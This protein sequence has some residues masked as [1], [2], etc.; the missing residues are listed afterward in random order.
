MHK[1]MTRGFTLIELLIVVVLL[2][3]IA[4]VSLPSFSAYDQQKI[5]VAATEAANILRLAISEARRTQG[6][7][8]VDGQS[9]PGHLQLY[10]SNAL[11]EQ[12]PAAGTSAVMDP[13]TKTAIDLNVIDGTFSQGVILS[14]A[15][16]TGGSPYPRLLID[17]SKATEMHVFDAANNNKGVLQSGSGISLTLGEHQLPVY[18]DEKTGLVTWYGHF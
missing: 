2:G 12:P 18:L 7:V 13:L 3:V 8:L 1:N 15:F 11:A 17:G 16:I 5:N 6:Y 10:Y 14:P 4:T 9:K